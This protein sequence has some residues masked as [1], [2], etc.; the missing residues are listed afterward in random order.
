MIKKAII[1]LYSIFI[2]IS[3]YSQ[4]TEI[5]SAEYNWDNGP[6]IPLIAFDGN[7]NSSVE[8]IISSSSLTFPSGGAHVF[9]IRVQNEDGD[10]SPYFKRVINFPVTNYTRDINITMLEYFWDT[11]PG[12]GSG[13]PLLAFDGAYDQALEYA[14]SNSIAALNGPHVLNIRAKDINGNWSPTFKR[15]VV[16]EDQQLVRDFKIISAEYNWD[17]GPSIPLIAFDG[18]FNSSVEDIISSSSF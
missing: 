14:T 15:V 5:I 11:D 7:F 16:F 18:N 9:N 12:E 3:I 10:W 8:D 6:S 17:N 1:F 2:S 4:R 13:T